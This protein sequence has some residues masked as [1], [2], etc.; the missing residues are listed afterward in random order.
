MIFNNKKTAFARGYANHLTA[1]APGIRR[2]IISNTAKVSK[3]PAFGKRGKKQTGN[4][5]QRPEIAGITNDFFAE[6]GKHYVTV[7]LKAGVVNGRPQVTEPEKCKTRLWFNLSGL[8]ENLFPPMRNFLAGQ[9][10]EA[11]LQV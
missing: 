4:S 8:P 10:P 5:P 9:R 6:S 7:I 3:R 11:P 2:A 1:A